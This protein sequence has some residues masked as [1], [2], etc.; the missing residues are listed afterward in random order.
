MEENLST[1]RIICNSRGQLAIFVALVFQVLFVLFA[2]AINVALIVHDKINLQNSVD[3]AAYYAASK[4]A[5]MLNAIAHQNYQIRQSWKLLAWRYRVLSTAGLLQGTQ[6]IH[7]SSPTIPSATHTETEWI[8]AS[9]S[10]QNHFPTVCINYVPTWI[11]PPAPPSENSCKNRNLV[12]PEIPVIPVIAGFNPINLV[13]NQLSGNLQQNFNI[14]CSEVGLWN[15]W[16]MK[17]MKESYRQDMAN[18]RRVIEPLAKAASRPAQA[19]VDLDGNSIYQG[20]FQTLRK[21]LTWSN[22]QEDPQMT[23]YNSL[24]PYADNIDWLKPIMINPHFLYTDMITPGCNAQIKGYQQPPH[25]TASP[26]WAFILGSLQGNILLTRPAHPIPDYLPERLI[27]GYEKNPWIQAYVAVQAQTT[28]RQIFHPF[29]PAVT[30][31]AKAYAKPFGGRIG[32]WYGR[33]WGPNDEESS[34]DKVDVRGQPRTQAGGLMDS[35]TDP[36]RLPNYSRYPGD[37]LGLASRLAQASLQNLVT[38][39]QGSIYHYYDT[40]TSIAMGHYNDPL[41]WDRMTNS[42]VP[43]RTY[44]IAAIVPDLFDITYYSIDANYWANYGRRIATNRS[45]LGIPDDVFVRPDLGFRS[46]VPA[47]EGYSVRNQIE[48]SRG[49][50]LQLPSSFYYVK[51]FQHLLTGWIPGPLANNYPSPVEDPNMPFGVCTQPDY[52]SGPN[53]KPN[54]PPH[55]GSCIMGGRVGYSVKLVSRSYLGSSNFDIGQGGTSGPIK[56]PPPF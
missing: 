53:T 7:P 18:R 3:L 33:N 12:V 5:E 36:D 40:Y 47:L 42:T 51:D 19:W 49:S 20:A 8:G 45:A 35:Y 24:E 34:G 29:G 55:P 31:T 37:P 22:S 16:F 52:T 13:I 44:E 43:P 28:S 54:M 25:N 2:M 46:Q 4:Q 48:S 27:S 10:D 11:S 38:S 26:T 32:P 56:N 41:P 6:A 17:A 14:S 23:L 9:I 15:W 50:G 1:S 39:F 30:I 21:N